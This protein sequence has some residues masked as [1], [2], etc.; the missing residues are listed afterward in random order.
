MIPHSTIRY[1][2]NK[3]PIDLKAEDKII[4]SPIALNKIKIVP[5]SNPRIGLLPDKGYLSSTFDSDYLFVF[6]KDVDLQSNYLYKVDFSKA[7]YFPGIDSLFDIDKFLSKK[8]IN[9]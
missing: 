9:N 5:I 3:D 8:V 7:N 4:P 2:I 1:L 6:H